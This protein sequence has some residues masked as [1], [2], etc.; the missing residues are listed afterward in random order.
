MASARIQRLPGIADIATQ[1][2]AIFGTHLLPGIAPLLTRFTQLFTLLGRHFAHLFVH[3][4]TPPE[5]P[6]WG[7]ILRCH[8]YCC[9]SQTAQQK[10]EDGLF[11]A[12][13][14]GRG[15]GQAAAG[16]VTILCELPCRQ[17]LAMPQPET[18]VS[19]RP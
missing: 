4:R 9:G 11:H 3:L 18:A 6:G 5:L 8:R 2:V 16:F 13:I 12:C 10:N 15:P 14:L 7:R 1:L 19:F 17:H